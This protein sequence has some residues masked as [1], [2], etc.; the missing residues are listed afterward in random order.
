VHD[1]AWSKDLTVD[2]DGHGVVSHTGS[3]VL[4]LLADNTGLTAALSGALA[5]RG[6]TPVHDRGRVL[7]D[8]AVC[9]ADGGRVLSD[10]AVLRD[11]PELYGPVASDPTVWRT[12]DAVGERERGHIATARA[13]VRRRVWA[14]IEARHGAI[15]PSRVA[16][17]DLGKTVVIRMDATIQ[18]AH[19]DKEG[20]AG[21]FKGTFGHHPL[22][23]WCDNTGE[24]LALRLRPGNAGSNTAADHLAVLGEAIAQIPDPHRRDLL[25]TVDGAGAT[26]DL[27]RHIT[28]LN[29]VHGRRVHYSVGFDLDH[30]AR[31]AIGHVREDDW[32]QVWNRD[33]HPR[34]LD[35]EHA[36]GVV[37]LTGLLRTS[38]GGDN[39][40]NWPPDMRILCRRERPSAGAQLCALE[41]ADGWRYQLVATNTPGRQLDFLEARHRAHARVEDRVRCGK[42]TGLDHLPS[43][44]MSINA[45]WCVTAMIA[46][47]LLRWFALLCLPPAFGDTEPKTLRYR[48]LHTAA[49]IVRGQR[50]RKIKIPETWPWAHEL[51]AAFDLAFALTP[52]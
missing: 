2:V 8:L 18:I 49:R 40:E 16:D 33:G 12:L 25:I 38:H 15:P 48:L 50:K 36:A 45:A 23:A 44:S 39:L 22:A 32:Q 21:T 26:L 41:E 19:S 51:A 10:L 20:A 7:G 29:A 1:N 14:L 3:A 31:A 42:A 47:D 52:T 37:E 27:I 28:T 35:G 13:R 17:V 5:R 30:R 24:A 9:I 4:R 46:T 11:Q 34:D 43:T 6:F